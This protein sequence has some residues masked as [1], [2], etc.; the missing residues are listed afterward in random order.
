MDRIPFPDE[1]FD[2]VVSEFIV[3]PTSA[4]TDVGQPEMARVL[5][6]DGVIA[7]TDVIVPTEPPEE[8]RATLREAGVEYLCVATQDD[9]RG[10]MEEAGMTAV[11]VDDLTPLV[12]PRWERRLLDAPDAGAAALLFGSGPWSLGR[13][14]QYN[15]V[16]GVKPG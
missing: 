11:R 13:G 16:T 8:V 2:G 10:W 6:Q 1:S 14:L 4:V 5:R 3:Y 9:F 12:A 7:L 15:L